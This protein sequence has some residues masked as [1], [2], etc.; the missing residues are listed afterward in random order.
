[1]TIGLVGNAKYG[2]DITGGLFAS[3][4]GLCDPLLEA[5]DFGA[6]VEE[7]VLLNENLNFRIFI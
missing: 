4:G 3:S 1:M 5:L 6:G 7:A 2:G